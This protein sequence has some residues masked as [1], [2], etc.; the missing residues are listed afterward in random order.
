GCGPWT[1]TTGP[2]PRL[3]PGP[4]GDSPVRR[5]LPGCIPGPAS[6][7]HSA[8]A[9]SPPRLG[10]R[11]LDDRTDVPTVAAGISRFKHMFDLTGRTPVRYGIERLFH[12]GRAPGRKVSVGQR[13]SPSPG[14]EGEGEKADDTQPVRSHRI[15]RS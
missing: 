6:D 3:S 13:P 5:R 7:A 2:A 8:L 1:V 4:R 9:P 12:P 15:T 14:I 10:R 11:P